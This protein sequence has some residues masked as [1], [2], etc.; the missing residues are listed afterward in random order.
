MR[1]FLRTLDSMTIDRSVI[2]IKLVRTFRDSP[3]ILPAPYFLAV[4]FN[5]SVRSYNRERHSV[6]QHLVKFIL[7]LLFDLRKLV[8]L[9]LMLRNLIQNLKTS[10]GMS[11]RDVASYFKLFRFFYFI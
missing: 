2:Y 8:D 10:V 6:P 1:I 7:F 11:V 4:V 5:N 9:D 3:R